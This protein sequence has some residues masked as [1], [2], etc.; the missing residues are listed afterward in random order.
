MKQN[1]IEEGRFTSEHA[2]GL[3]TVTEEM[4]MHR[5][6]ELARIAG[7]PRSQVLDSDVDQARRE[8]TGEELLNPN[9]T[10]AERLTEDERWDPMPDTTARQAETVSAPDEQLFA[11]RLVEEGVEEA[12]HEQMTEAARENLPRDEE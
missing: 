9:P 7:R 5:A 2:H 3:G 11:E 4:V 6:R 10:A 8:L 12:E 1:H